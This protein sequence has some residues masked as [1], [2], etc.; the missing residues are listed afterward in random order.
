MEKYK[1]T[2]NFVTRK[3]IDK[4]YLFPTGEE[5]QNFQGAIF[6]DEISLM[7]WE[8]LKEEKTISELS[9]IVAVEYAVDYQTAKEDITELLKQYID[10]HIVF[11][12]D[13]KV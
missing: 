8:L 13:N 7:V 11:I 5:K 12:V 4:C 1:R 9:E 2:D 3:I 6:L 10:F